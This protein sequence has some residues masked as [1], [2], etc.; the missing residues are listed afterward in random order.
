VRPRRQQFSSFILN[1]ALSRV[2][3]RTMDGI[4]TQSMRSGARPVHRSPFQM[5]SADDGRYYA[6]RTLDER[7]LRYSSRYR[8][9][10]RLVVKRSRARL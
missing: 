4:A 10:I 7:R 9:I 2:K 6:A 1:P 5:L 8:S 3:D